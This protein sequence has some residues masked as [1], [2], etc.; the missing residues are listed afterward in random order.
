MGYDGK[1]GVWRF[2]VEHFSRYGLLDSDDE[3][4][5]EEGRP[6]G[7]SPQGGSN[8]GGRMDSGEWSGEEGEE[9]EEAMQ[10]AMQERRCAPCLIGAD[11]LLESSCGNAL[12][13]AP[14]HE[15]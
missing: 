5:P 7:E 4:G 6:S 8:A 10:E 3:G 1:E 11:A 12:L 2:E 15:V 13:G 14:S 9:E